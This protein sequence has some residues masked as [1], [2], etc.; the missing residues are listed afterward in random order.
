MPQ[1]DSAEAAVRKHHAGQIVLDRPP[2]GGRRANKRRS[3]ELVVLHEVVVH[4]A[5]FGDGV[6]GQHGLLRIDGR[7]VSPLLTLIA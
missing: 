6:R 5:V 4:D 7:L 2:I 1:V 3:P